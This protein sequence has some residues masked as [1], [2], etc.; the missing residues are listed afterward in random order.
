MIRHG[1]KL[2]KL[3]SARKNGEKIKVPRTHESIEIRIRDQE[4][5]TLF[6]WDP[7]KGNLKQGIYECLDFTQRGLG[8]SLDDVF[9]SPLSEV[10]IVKE[11]VQQIKSDTKGALE[12][13][14]SSLS[15]G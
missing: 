9:E 5:K 3:G 4:G 10:P 15:K 13:I 14:G 11:K 6:R 2:K 7:A 8:V 12:R 1:F